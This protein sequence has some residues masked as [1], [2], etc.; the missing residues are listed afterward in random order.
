MK[1]FVFASCALL[2][3]AALAYPGVSDVAAMPKPGDTV[4]IK[5]TL[6][7]E[8]AVITIGVYDRTTG[9][10]ID[11]SCYNDIEGA[12]NRLVKP[13]SCSIVW[14]KGAAWSA[15]GI[16]DADVD[17]RVRAWA[18]NCPPD[19]AVISLT[20]A[21]ET[22]KYYTS[23]NAFPPSVPFGSVAYKTT[24]L[25]LRKIPAANVEFRMGSPDQE[26]ARAPVTCSSGSD[27]RSYAEN[28]H[29]VILS[30]D[31]YL[32]VYPV[33]HAQQVKVCGSYQNGHWGTDDAGNLF[34]DIREETWPVDR[35]QYCTVRSYMHEDGCKG[36]GA[37][38]GYVDYQYWPRN[39]FTLNTNNTPKCSCTSYPG[40]MS[41]YLNSW[42][43]KTGFLFDLPTQAQWEFACRAGTQ[44]PGFW[45]RGVADYSRMMIT[46]TAGDVGYDF[47]TELD[48]YAWTA[49]N[50]TN[51]T[52]K[53]PVPHTVGLL[54][55]NA[56]GIYDMLGNVAEFCRD[57]CYGAVAASTDPEI[58]PVGPNTHTDGVFLRKDYISARGGCYATDP[59]HVRP[60]FYFGMSPANAVQE[61]PGM[62]RPLPTGSGWGMG[63]RL[64]APATAVR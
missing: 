14:K 6:S 18:T 52:V 43:S 22:V 47:A 28:R 12:V 41:P 8:P 30:E 40:K 2:A 32:G 15:R 62:V 31:F 4:K 21:A 58:D 16:A 39:G 35:L 64:W 5:Y 37:Q 19:Y 46:N 17:V 56:F 13:G 42:R 57:L 45:K 29:W 34:K 53:M 55:P 51:E 38:D 50:S 27:P 20:N 59:S 33:T 1:T 63:Y 44:G 49:H 3:A 36:P 61:V 23:T 10:K 24:H 7:G 11:E 54:K 25:V 60:A 26:F 9:A 48:Q